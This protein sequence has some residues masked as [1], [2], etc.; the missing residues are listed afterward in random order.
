VLSIEKQNKRGNERKAFFITLCFWITCENLI[1][2]LFLE[3]IFFDKK[4]EM[5]KAGILK[6]EKKYLF[7]T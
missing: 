4:S 2:V 5:K 6:I 1:F 7:L 3:K